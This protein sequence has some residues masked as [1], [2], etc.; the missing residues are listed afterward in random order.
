MFLKPTLIHKLN[1]VA[2]GELVTDIVLRV[3]EIP[4]RAADSATTPVID[5]DVTDSE[6]MLAEVS[7]H[8]S[9]I[10]DPD[11]R[12]QFTSVISRYP[13]TPTPPGWGPSRVP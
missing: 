7:S 13:Q 5:G 10:Q 11:L 6:V 4:S 9:A 8:V 12:Q 2:G 1:T 3:G